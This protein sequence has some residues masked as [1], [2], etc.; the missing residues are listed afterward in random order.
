MQQ[1]YD[2]LQ[3]RVTASRLMIGSSVVQ[4][5]PFNFECSSPS[6]AQTKQSFVHLRTRSLASRLAIGSSN[7]RL[8]PISGFTLVELIITIAILAIIA[9]MAAPSFTTMYSRQ[10]LESSAR[11]LVMKISEARSQAV[12]LRQSTG[13]CL[14]S[15]SDDDCATAIAIPKEETQRIFIAR[16]DHGVTSANSSSTNL[17]FRRNGSL[18]AQ[19][20]FILERQN[21][22]YCIRVGVIGDTTIKEGACT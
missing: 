22:S 12:L 13:V 17:S 10:K 15:L 21:L 4:L 2:D 19:K 18:A 7:T 8:F 1:A 14:A 5:H 3:S 6:C 16:L 20:D 9:L 11:E